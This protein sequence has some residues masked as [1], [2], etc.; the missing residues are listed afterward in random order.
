MAKG[1]LLTYVMKTEKIS[2]KQNLRWMYDIAKGMKHLASQGI[3]HRF[4]IV[5]KF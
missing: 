1:D 5:K 4:V 2:M 3:V